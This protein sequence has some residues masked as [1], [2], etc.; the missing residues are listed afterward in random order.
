MIAEDDI[1]H[2]VTQE[3]GSNDND[4]EI[5]R[6]FEENRKGLKYTKESFL[7]TIKMIKTLAEQPKGKRTYKAQIS[8]LEAVNGIGFMPLNTARRL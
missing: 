7:A 3:E 4:S 1:K 8:E 2:H 6:F 5:T